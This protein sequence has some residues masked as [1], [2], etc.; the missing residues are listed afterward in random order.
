MNEKKALE[1]G[2]K[3]KAYL[4][5]VMV[6]SVSSTLS[7]SCPPQRLCFCVAGSQGPAAVGV[8]HWLCGM[9]CAECD[10]SLSLRPSYAIPK[11]LDKTGLKLSD[12]DVFE[13]HEAFAVSLGGTNIKFCMCLSIGD[14]NHTLACMDEYTGPD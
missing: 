6:E 4:R 13:Y 2:Y 7:H 11:L 5:L 10:L 9:Q 8:R 12:I 1:L 14:L 3:P